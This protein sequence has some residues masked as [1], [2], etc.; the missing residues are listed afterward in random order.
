MKVSRSYW[1]GLGSGLILSAMLTLIFSSQQGKSIVQS[2]V[3]PKATIP[4]TEQTKQSHSSPL[5]QSS[6]STPKQDS[7]SKAQISTQVDRNFVV[8]KGASAEQIADLLYAQD[9]IKDKGA[10]IEQT[11]QM[12]AERQFRAGA[13]SLA[14]GL[15]EEELIRR[16]LK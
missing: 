12:G 10:F 16:L 14:L 7:P 1:I 3:N 4:S 13:Y 6:E 8:P 9:F 5:F 15:T 11:H 2:D